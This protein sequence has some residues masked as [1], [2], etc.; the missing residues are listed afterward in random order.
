MPQVL[1]SRLQLFKTLAVKLNNKPSLTVSHPSALQLGA[2]ADLA[3]LGEANGSAAHFY[4]LMLEF[5]EKLF[6]NT[7]EQH[8]FE[9]RL[10]C[11]FGMN[12]RRLFVIIM[13][14]VHWYLTSLRI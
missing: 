7:L 6:D 11:M 14:R 10:R 3:T 9:D 8:I 13:M 1:W 4:E 12:V 2:L 5:C